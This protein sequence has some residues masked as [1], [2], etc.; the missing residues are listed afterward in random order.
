M[1]KEVYLRVLIEELYVLNY[2]LDRMKKQII[3]FG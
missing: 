1:F 3:F 2:I